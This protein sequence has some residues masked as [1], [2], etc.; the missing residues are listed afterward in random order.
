MLFGISDKH[1]QYRPGILLFCE[2]LEE[3]FNGLIERDYDV[4]WTVVG[5]IKPDK[6]L[7]VWYWC[8][9][10]INAL[11][12]ET[13]SES[14]DQAAEIPSLEKI[15]QTLTSA[16][17]G[18][19]RNITPQQKTKALRA[20]FAV[21]C[22][23]SLSLKPILFDK[24]LPM[25]EDAPSTL[26]VDES[27]RALSLVQVSKRPV[28]KLFRS[29]RS[30]ASE[31][32]GEHI[33]DSLQYNGILY[34][35]SLNSH[36]LYTIG[37]LRIQ[38]VDSMTAHLTWDRQ[39]RTISIFRFP[40]YCAM[41]INRQGDVNV[42][43]QWVHPFIHVKC[44]SNS[45]SRV[46]AALLP[47][48]SYRDLPRPDISALHRELLLTY[49]LLF[50]QS[51]RSRNLA[52]ILLNRLRKSVNEVDPLLT[53]LCTASRHRNLFSKL[54]C[55]G[56]NIDLPAELFPISTIDINNVFVESST[57]S[58]QYDFPI[59][60]SRLLALQEYNLR[61]QPSKV[62]DLWR[63][64]RNPLQWYT[65]WAVILVGGISILLATFQ[66]AVGI[67]QLYF[68]TPSH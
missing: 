3:C 27:S 35:S 49:R 20:I 33:N 1:P 36:S 41:S 60:G 50:G 7:E 17:S 19:A 9:A 52:R 46:L 59:F 15:Y 32:S 56:T 61:Q 68:T 62:R 24:Q 29:F 64:R 8:F 48:E 65:F 25:T 18:N 6:P 2:Y 63:D 14:G 16:N 31:P 43:Q 10:V 30:I 28:N 45:V 39:N 57:Y 54:F 51:S 38:W 55:G 58:A 11:H 22:W 26:K 5:R 66:L 44:Y 12:N 4:I 21:I 34:A 40:S 67:G 47:S 42:L 53:T 23:T 37:R 13:A